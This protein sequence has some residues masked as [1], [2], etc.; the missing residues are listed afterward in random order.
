MD[1]KDKDIA[2]LKKVNERERKLARSLWS[3]HA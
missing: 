3:C 2:E 1:E